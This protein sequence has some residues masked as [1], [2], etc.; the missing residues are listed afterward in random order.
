MWA[1]DESMSQ[2][3]LPTLAPAGDLWS[4]ECQLKSSLETVLLRDVVGLA[5]EDFSGGRSEADK[6]RVINQ[7]TIQRK[8]KARA[9]RGQAPIQPLA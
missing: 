3:G 8:A 5:T 1:A 6:Q 9:A 4:V 7:A 2:V